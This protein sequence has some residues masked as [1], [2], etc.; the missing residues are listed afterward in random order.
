MLNDPLVATTAEGD[1]ISISRTPQ[2]AYHAL[3]INHNRPPLDDLNV[4][5][6]MQCAV[7]RQEVL[8]TAALG[9]GAVVGPITSPAYLSDSVRAALPR[10]GRREG[11]A[12]PRRRRLRRRRHHRD[13]RLAGRVRHLGGNE[14]QSLQAQLA[15]VGIDLEIEAM[16]IGT[17]VDRWLAAD[18]DTAVALNGGRPDPDVMYGRYF[19]S[20][21]NLNQIASYNSPELDEL[22]ARGKATSDPAERKQI[23]DEIS[24]VPRG[25][26]GVAVDVLQLQL[27]RHDR[28]RDE[29]HPHAQ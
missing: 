14:A 20:T 5:L 15:E 6:A 13:H 26:R 3:M 28:R 23:Y 9:E 29:L 24:R 18:F 21:G 10:E 11:Q 2:L 7:D 16:E 4:R 19:P 22:F 8:D 12:V 1:G 25:Q 17:Y 27:R